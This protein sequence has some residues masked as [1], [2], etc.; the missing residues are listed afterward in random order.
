MWIACFVSRALWRKLYHF[1]CSFKHLWQA[2]LLYFFSEELQRR[3]HQ[4][5][6]KLRMEKRREQK[7]VATGATSYSS[8]DR[9][10]ASKY[11]LCMFS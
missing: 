9:S 11:L 7:S 5:Q 10:A 6:K 2:F 8:A 4:R 1:Q 3:K